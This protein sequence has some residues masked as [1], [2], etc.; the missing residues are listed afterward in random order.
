MRG[1][2]T[3]RRFAGKNPPT[4]PQIYYS[5]T[6]AA[7]KVVFKVLDIEGKTLSQWNGTKTAGLHKTTWDMTRPG[8]GG[9]G[10]RGP[11]PAG[12]YR[13]MMSVD[14]QEFSQVLRLESDPNLPPGRRAALEELLPLPE[15][16]EIH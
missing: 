9:K 6:E 8:A 13:L 4:G 1:K 11:A 10:G 5:L 2:T 14:G 7:E 15:D 16:R 3:N 12:D